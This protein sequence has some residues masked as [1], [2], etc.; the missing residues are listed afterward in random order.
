MASLG[1]NERALVDALDEPALVLEGSIVSF[2]NAAA[3]A[4]F[5][6]GIERR[7]CSRSATRMRLT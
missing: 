3:R 1:D 2:A 6:A 4:L 7:A 5:G